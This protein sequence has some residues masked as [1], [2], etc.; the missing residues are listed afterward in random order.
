[1][2]ESFTVLQYIINCHKQTLVQLLEFDTICNR[3][4]LCFSIIFLAVFIT[5]LSQLASTTA[6]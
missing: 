3:K 1:M 4:N 2:N 6:L 5:V